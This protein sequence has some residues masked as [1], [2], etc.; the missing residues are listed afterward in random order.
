MLTQISWIKQPNLDSPD[1]SSEL[2]HAKI[3]AQV[4]E[5]IYPNNLIAKMRKST[6]AGTKKKPPPPVESAG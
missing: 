4:K 2:L 6:P 3:I 1:A 5:C